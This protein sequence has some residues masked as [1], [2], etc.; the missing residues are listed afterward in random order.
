MLGFGWSRKPVLSIKRQSGGRGW[1]ETHPDDLVSTAS[2]L[3]RP[4]APA[5][6]LKGVRIALAP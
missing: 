4:D 3:R 6:T 2:S 1:D 5:A